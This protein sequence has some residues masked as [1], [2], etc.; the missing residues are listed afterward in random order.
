MNAFKIIAFYIK[1]ERKKDSY[2][3]RNVTLLWSGQRFAAV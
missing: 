3:Y 2:T 1:K